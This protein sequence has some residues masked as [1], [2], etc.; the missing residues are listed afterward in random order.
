MHKK[1]A[2]AFFVKIEMYGGKGAL[3]DP[4]SQ[5]TEHKA[6]LR[7]RPRGRLGMAGLVRG[8][9][10]ERP[11]GRFGRVGSA[12]GC[13][14][15]RPRLFGSAH[16]EGAMRYHNSSTILIDGLGRP[17]QLDELFVGSSPIPLL[18]SFANTLCCEV[19]HLC[20]LWGEVCRD[21]LRRQ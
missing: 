20:P 2:S 19:I 7:G 1:F 15:G 16:G 3:V 17:L 14:R 13:V 10:Q 4:P 5:V 18:V 8:H 12:R 11:R 21:A 9:V 6:I